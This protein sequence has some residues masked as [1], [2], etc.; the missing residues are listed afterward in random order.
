MFTLISSIS[1]FASSITS[2][3][4]KNQSII[5]ISLSFISNF[6]INSFLVF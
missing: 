2:L 3:S 4:G 1:F 6:S 5:F